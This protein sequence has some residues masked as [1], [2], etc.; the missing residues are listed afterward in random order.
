MTRVLCPVCSNNGYEKQFSGKDY[1]CGT[2][3]EVFDVAKCQACGF[4]FVT[5]PPDLKDLGK[6]Y[7]E[8]Y[9][10][11]E[12]DPVKG[13][14]K[15]G[16]GS[17]KV[18]LAMKFRSDGKVLDIGCGDG[19]FLQKMQGS[20]FDVYGLDVSAKA[21]E[22]TKAK[23]GL[24]GSSDRICN[25]E[26]KDCGF[27]PEQFN[28]V[29]MWHVLEHVYNPRE[30]LQ[31]IK[32]VLGQDGI[33]VIEVP[34]VNSLGYRIFGKYCF[35]MEIPRHVSHYSISTLVKLL[36][37]EGFTV[38]K[39]EYPRFTF[40]LSPFYSLSMMLKDK[41]TP[42]VLKTFL[43][44]LASPVLIILIVFCNIFPFFGDDMVVYAEKRRG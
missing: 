14:P 28:L 23:L 4:L 32:R 5:N 24:D 26:L 16:F 31:E 21:V 15:R 20:G 19:D 18:S 35:H 10:I 3:N 22:I 37:L 13:K 30:I 2:S 9:Y 7:P 44:L 39:A 38:R 6:Y 36:D 27:K 42:S 33:L 29:T 34:N 1:R 8:N 12:T 43:L 41:G 25:A 40:P 11:D 17:K